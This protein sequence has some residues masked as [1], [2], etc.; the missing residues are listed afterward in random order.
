MPKAAS[1]SVVVNGGSPLVHR[2]SGTGSR[3]REQNGS[4]VKPTTTTSTLKKESEQAVEIVM[5]EDVV[6]VDEDGVIV[7]DDSYLN[8]SG[9][10]IEEEHAE[11]EDLDE[12]GEVCEIEYVAE[13]EEPQPEIEE[14]ELGNSSSGEVVINGTDYEYLLDTTTGSSSHKMDANSSSCSSSS[15]G[16]DGNRNHHHPIYVEAEQ[17]EMGDGV[18]GFTLVRK[19]GLELIVDHLQN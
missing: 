8:Y 13:E 17:V 1:N 6:V 12:D 19:G 11:V 9:E 15:G 4:S 7:D 16:G 10:I 14:I 18:N 3:L 5:E 2:G